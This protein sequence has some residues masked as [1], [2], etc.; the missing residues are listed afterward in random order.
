MLAFYLKL[1]KRRVI[2]E[3]DEPAESDDLDSGS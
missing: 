3:R 2:E 1:Q